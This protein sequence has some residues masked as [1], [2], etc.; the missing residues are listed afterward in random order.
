MSEKQ[1]IMDEAFDAGKVFAQK[2]ILD[3]MDE[4]IRE[5]KMQKI[6]MD[7]PS[8]E[9]AQAQLNAVEFMK[10]WVVSGG[11]EDENGNRVCLVW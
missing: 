7:S 11:S 4:V 10:N 8:H 6:K 9:I 3:L 1:E 2:K 5:Y